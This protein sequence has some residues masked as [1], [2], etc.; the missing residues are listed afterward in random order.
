M[1]LN[2]RNDHEQRRDRWWDGVRGLRKR[3]DQGCF[4]TG[5][6][7]HSDAPGHAHAAEGLGRTLAAAGGGWRVGATDGFGI[8]DTG[9]VGA[10]NAFRRGHFSIGAVARPWVERPGVVDF[11]CGGGSTMRLM[12]ELPRR[13][14]DICRAAA[15]LYQ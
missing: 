14:P 8:P 3:F 5:R 7:R 6:R 4:D 11:W 15:S 1:N 10:R 12:Q 2:E 9:M 13:M